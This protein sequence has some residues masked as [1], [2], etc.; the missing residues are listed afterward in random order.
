MKIREVG[1]WNALSRGVFS[2]I[3]REKRGGRG[4]EGVFKKGK[5][6]LNPFLDKKIVMQARRRAV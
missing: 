4:Y 3:K 6:Y 1:I 2:Q 5:F